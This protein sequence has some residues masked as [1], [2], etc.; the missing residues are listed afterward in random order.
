MSDSE[1]SDEEDYESSDEEDFK[2][3]DEYFDPKIVAKEIVRREEFL[4]IDGIFYQKIS[5]RSR[6]KIGKSVRYAREKIRSELFHYSKNFRFS[7]QFLNKVVDEI[8]MLGTPA[9]PKYQPLS[10]Q[11]FIIDRIKLIFGKHNPKEEVISSSGR[12]VDLLFDVGSHIVILEIDEN[13]HFDRKDEKER[14]QDIQND[15]KGF[16]I[17]LIRF[18]PDEYKG[19]SAIIVEGDRVFPNNL[20]WAKRFSELEDHLEEALD[21]KTPKQNFK[22]IKLFYPDSR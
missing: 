1:S 7:D 22:V 18:N 21:E 6:D 17:I 2:V 4:Y 3:R 14:E 15:Y 12:R 10:K 19:E 20:I 8:M 5:E 11:K 9:K 16:P 13:A